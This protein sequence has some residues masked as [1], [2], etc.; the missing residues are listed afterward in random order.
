MKGKMERVTKKLS[1]YLKATQVRGRGSLP[2][3]KELAK[4]PDSEFIEMAYLVLLK[5]NPDPEGFHLYF[6]K[7][8]SREMSRDDL[9]LGL[10]QSSEFEKTYNQMPL[11][12]FFLDPISVGSAEAFR[13][14]VKNPPYQGHQ[15]NEL[16]N[17]Y[18]WIDPDWRKFARDLQVVPTT[19]QGM[20]RKAFE[21]VQTIYGANLLKKMNSHSVVLGVGTGHE[22]IV[23]W[24]AKHCKKVYATDLFRGEW[25]H[26]GA[27]EGDPSVLKKPEKY[28][29]F[30]YPRER[31]TFLPMDG[32][33]LA[34]KDSFFDL[35]FSLSS[36]EH[37]G[38]KDLS[39]LAVREMERVLKP[40][41]LAIIATEYILNHREHTDFFNKHDLLECVVKPSRMKLVQNI[42]FKIP[43]I[44][45]D[46][47]IK[48]PSEIY[49]TPHLSLT[50]G[51]IVWTSVI[52]FFEKV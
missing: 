31:L 45:I 8:Q 28:Q 1:G 14:Y 3:P 27:T 9:V 34:F 7:I 37:F 41:G 5:R 42:S 20:H 24:M 13:P 17:P 40:G 50:D 23:Y 22:P 19:F 39:A 4:I 10:L 52:L 2:E 51:N 43:R 25:V 6:E 12:E 15:L 26:G 46:N 33:H 49:R 18:K 44:F 36:I 48:F 29:P 38:G 11:H 16:A 35:A 30:E 21:W 47:P 32:C